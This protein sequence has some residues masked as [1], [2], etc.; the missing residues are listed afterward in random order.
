MKYPPTIRWPTTTFQSRFGSAEWLTPYID[1]TVKVLAAWGKRIA[2]VT[3]GFP[4]TAWKQSTKLIEST[5][6]TFAMPVA[7]D[8]PHHCL[9]DSDSGMRILETSVRRELRSWT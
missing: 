3:P 8:R 6:S 5:H 1:E 9:N 2:V 4:L 7:K